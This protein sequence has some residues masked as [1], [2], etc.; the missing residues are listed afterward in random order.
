MW[1]DRQIS[2]KLRRAWVQF[3]AVVLCGARQTGKT[4]VARHLL[5][6]AE[7]LTFDISLHAE[8]ARLDPEG[9]FARRS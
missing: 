5:P 9:S 8:Q 4:S 6:N 7:F 2:E 1:I 3:P